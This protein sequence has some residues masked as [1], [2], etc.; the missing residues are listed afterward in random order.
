MI[1]VR[2]RIAVAGEKA[3]EIEEVAIIV[4]RQAERR[5]FFKFYFWSTCGEVSE[6]EDGV[7]LDFASSEHYYEILW[8][9][10]LELGL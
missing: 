4:F 2:E 1:V 9:A 10:S 7:D 5:L 8:D 3:L 6:T